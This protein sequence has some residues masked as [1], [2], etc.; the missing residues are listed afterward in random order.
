MVK[1]QSGKY[2]KSSIVKD[3]SI[4]KILNEGEWIVNQKYTYP[5]GNPRKDFV[6]KV[7]LEGQEYTMRINKT[8]R[9]TL[10]VAWGDETRDWVGN[11]AV[12][13]LMDALV[14]GKMQKIVILTALS[15]DPKDPKE[16]EEQPWS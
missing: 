11:K 2:L 6:L 5:D 13:K 12:V 14:S 7:D 10:K 9:E 4:I 3:G 16:P 15:F 1:L 8:N